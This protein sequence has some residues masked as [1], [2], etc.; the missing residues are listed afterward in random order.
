MVPY[1]QDHY[2]NNMPSNKKKGNTNNK[3]K[4]QDRRAKQSASQDFHATANEFRE[5][6]LKG[7]EEYA[8]GRSYA[9]VELQSEA[10]K[11]GSEKLPRFEDSLTKAHALIE[12]AL[13]KSAIQ[14]DFATG[15]EWKKV[16]QEGKEISSNALQI[17]ESRLSDG[18]LTRFR[19]EECWIDGVDYTSAVPHTERL[20]PIDYTTAINLLTI[21]EPSPD[22]IKSIKKAIMFC[23]GFIS[24]GYVINLEAG[25]ALQGGLPGKKT[26]ACFLQIFIFFSAIG[27]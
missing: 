23:T 25:G 5:L 26:N 18:T 3:K 12:L 1:L 16:N 2:F 22:T 24:S 6:L 17:F 8:K 19:K 15:D 20:G 21:Y 7:R 9:A 4:V 14:T 13:A 10:L 11:L 27:I